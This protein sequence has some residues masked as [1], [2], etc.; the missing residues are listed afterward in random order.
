MTAIRLLVA[1]DQS[2]IRLALRTLAE[3][4]TDIDLIAEAE[5]GGQAVELIRATRPD[6]VLLDIRMPV[7]DGLEVLRRCCAEPALAATRIIMMTTFDIDQY[8]FEALENGAAGFITKDTDPASILHAVRVVAAG[9]SLLSPAVTR[10][11][12]DRFA[13]AAAVSGP[14]KP[15]PR[16]G[17]L[18]AREREIVGWVATGLSNDD[19]AAR[20]V[21]S[22]ATVRTHVGRAMLK[23][24]AR[25]RAQLVVIAYRSG[26]PIPE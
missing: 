25:D 1:D 21:V 5:D 19:I 26:L 17:A 10:K 11:V 14:A 24:A 22:P 18:T 23:L 7:M 9:E 16:L 12:I 3:G 20:L 8:I 6:V 15:H 13:S 2:L 4:E